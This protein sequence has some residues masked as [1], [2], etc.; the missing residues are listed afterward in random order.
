MVLYNLKAIDLSLCMGLFSQFWS[1][2]SRGAITAAS[3]RHRAAQRLP[4]R[5]YF[6]ASG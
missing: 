3:C 1:R 4:N 6:L 5:P 2:A